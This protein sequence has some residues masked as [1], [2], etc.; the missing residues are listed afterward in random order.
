M[1]LYKE[2]T[3]TDAGAALMSRILTN[4]GEPL[5]FEAVAVGSGELAADDTP[6]TFTAL[7]SEVKRLPI[8]SVERSGGTITVTARLATDTITADIYHREVGIVANGILLAYGNT[9]SQYDYIPAAGKNAAIQKTIRIPLAIGTMQTTFAEMDTTDL[10]THA[11]LEARVK[12]LVEPIVR[13]ISTDLA[14]AALDEAVHDVAREVAEEASADAYAAQVKAEEAAAHALVSETNIN[15]ALEETAEHI[16]DNVRHLTPAERP[17]FNNVL[18]QVG[19]GTVSTGES[20]HE[21]AAYAFRIDSPPAGKCEKITLNISSNAADIDAINPFYLVVLE[22]DGTGNYSAAAIS[23]ERQI[24]IADT[25][26]D[27]TFSNLILSGAKI[28]LAYCNDTSMTSIPDKMGLKVTEANGAG[29]A[30]TDKDLTETADYIPALTFTMAGMSSALFS[31]TNSPKVHIS[32]AERKKWNTPINAYQL[33]TG[34]DIT[35]IP[36]DTDLTRTLFAYKMCWDCKS[37]ASIAGLQMP[38]VMNAYGAFYGCEALTDISGTTFSLSLNCAYMFAYCKS[39]LTVGDAN[40]AGAENCGAMFLDCDNLTSTGTSTFRHLRYAQSMFSGCRKLEDITS[41]SLELLIYA[42]SMFGNCILNL[43]SVKHIAQRIN[44]VTNSIITIGIN[45]ELEG[46]SELA[47][48]LET[49]RGKG[50][51]TIV[52]YNTKTA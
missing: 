15:L 41:M 30:Y 4:G 18:M 11:A 38:C 29:I 14:E 6:A 39:L 2:I 32:E 43:E 36:A 31:H 9:G 22:D 25:T 13:D 42:Q 46:N 47:T 21:L 51:Q 34:Q 8:E 23:R 24:Q 20:T 44:I 50:W 3:I 26:A 35:G 33:Y 7:K 52:E 40:F 28:K 49:I 19:G 27:Y 16:A 45:A 48:A 17:K 10:V 5:T 12:T 1:A 37:L